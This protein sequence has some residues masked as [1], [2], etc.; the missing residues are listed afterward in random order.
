LKAAPK[1][2]QRR[3]TMMQKI[4]VLSTER[5]EKIWKDLSDCLGIWEKP[6]ILNMICSG[7]SCKYLNGELKVPGQYGMSL[8]PGP[9]C[10]CSSQLRRHGEMLWQRLPCTPKQIQHHQLTT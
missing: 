3:P 9:T 4:K 7:M 5:S 2:P 1:S 8:Q 10:T 6:E